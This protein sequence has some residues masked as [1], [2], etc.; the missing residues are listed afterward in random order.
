M[1]AF[2]NLKNASRVNALNSSFLCA[3]LLGHSVV[4]P[5]ELHLAIR[6]N[7]PVLLHY[8]KRADFIHDM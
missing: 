4:R 3:C 8:N 6:L 7:H 5:I 1:N 2:A